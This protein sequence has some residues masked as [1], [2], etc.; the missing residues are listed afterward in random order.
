MP[1]ILQPAPGIG[2]GVG[3]GVVRD[4]SG[5]AV[6]APAPNAVVGPLGGGGDAG[7]SAPRGRQHRPGGYVPRSVLAEDRPQLPGARRH[8]HAR[9]RPVRR[10]NASLASQPAGTRAPPVPQEEC[11]MS[12]STGRHGPRSRPRLSRPTFLTALLAR[13]RRTR[14]KG[15]PAAETAF[16]PV[17]PREAMSGELDPDL[18]AI[19][20]PPAAASAGACGCGG[21]CV[22]RGSSLAAHRRRRARASGRW[23]DF[24][25]IEI[26]PTLAIMRSS[27]A[28]CCVLIVARRAR[29]PE[30]G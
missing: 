11:L 16:I 28:R 22:G 13:P 10:A 25:P 18:L 12:K 27:S 21:S 23:R 26:A 1:G 14:V 3:G 9:L 2:F 24:L 17:D 8:P 15:G 6:G 5:Q 20:S 30:P 19:R 7:V 4:S 29:P